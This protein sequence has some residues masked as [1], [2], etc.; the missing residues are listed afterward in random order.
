MAMSRLDGCSPLTDAARRCAISP[1]VIVSSPAIMLSSVDLPQPEG[2]TSTRKPPLL[3]R[4][5]DALED[6]DARRSD[7]SQ[8]ADVEKRHGGYPFTAPAIRPRT[9]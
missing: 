2:P 5:V 1:A 8:V 4:E 6:L 3:D 7:L 9:K